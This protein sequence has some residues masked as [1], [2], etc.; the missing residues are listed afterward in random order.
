VRPAADPVWVLCGGATWEAASEDALRINIGPGAG[1]EIGVKLDGLEEKMLGRLPDQLRDLICIAAFVLAADCGTRRGTEKTV[2]DGRSWRRDFRFVIPVS[3]VQFWEGEEVLSS[4]RHTLGFLSDDHYEFHFVAGARDWGGRQLSFRPTTGRT[5]APWDHI[6]EVVLFSGGMDSFAGAV[7]EVLVDGRDVLLV[8]HRS[9][10]RMH[11]RQ[12][13]LVDD[14]RKR[15]RNAGPWHLGVT[16]EKRSEALRVENSQRSRSLLFASIAGAVAWLCNR[17]RVRF[18]ENGVIAINLPISDQLL[19]ALGTRTV[20]PVVVEGFAK[21]LTLVTA[22]PF[23]VDNPFQE[24]TRADVAALIRDAGAADLM[25]Y[26]WSCAR[27]RHAK[28]HQP[29]CGVCSQCVDRQFAVRTAGVLDQEPETLYEVDL[30]RDPLKERY[31]IQMALGYVDTARQLRALKTPEELLARFGAAGDAIP[32][33]ARRW[34]CSRDEAN[35]RLLALHRRHGQDVI[36]VLG[37]ELRART[38]DLGQVHPESMLGRYVGAGLDAGRRLHGIEPDGPQDAG[39][40]GS[41]H[42][43]SLSAPMDPLEML[44]PGQ[45]L[46][47][48][49]FIE[50]GDFWLIGLGGTRGVAVKDQ[51]GVRLISLLL[52]HA[53]HAFG[54]AELQAVLDGVEAP[55]GSG[56][57]PATD[58]ASIAGLRA[59]LAEVSEAEEEDLRGIGLVEQ[60]ARMREE[61]EEIQDQLVRDVGLG[62]RIRDL[63]PEPEKARSRTQ[64][65][66]GRAIKAIKGT[67]GGMAVGRHLANAIKSGSIVVYATAARGRDW[68]LDA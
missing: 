18:Y 24:S 12:K 2:D 42:R 58:R 10:T 64:K 68:Q 45:V 4:L 34:D 21:L 66:I 52:R 65:S 29:F 19:G 53:G 20:H 8:S 13:G 5:F 50:A 9:S 16:V 43:T 30:F 14:L 28:K 59:R 3:D 44:H 17:R 48:D 37:T 22:E 60:A 6:E 38:P 39:E 40:A 55:P 61:R 26:T 47:G 56:T 15:S 1:L 23:E 57:I 67:K 46:A 11:G 35:A 25:R 31:A 49:T 54:A 41:D 33:L 62:G 7:K 32:A 27:V 36:D 51:R 63:A